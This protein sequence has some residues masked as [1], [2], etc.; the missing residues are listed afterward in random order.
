MNVFKHFFEGRDVVVHLYLADK[1]DLTQKD[2][3]RVIYVFW[4]Y[5]TNVGV[6]CVFQ[7]F[8]KTGCKHCYNIRQH[9]ML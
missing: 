4:L 2:R 6:F 8:T 7:D 3:I 9:L 1:F 5:Q